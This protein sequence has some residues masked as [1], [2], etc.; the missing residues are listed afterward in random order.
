MVLFEER[1]GP[2]T[3]VG[4]KRREDF[5]RRSQYLIHRTLT[6]CSGDI[7]SEWCE[8]KKFLW[9]GGILLM[10]GDEDNG[11]GEKDDELW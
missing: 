4:N 2:I 10:L 3:D 6:I 9:Y 5:R 11:E 7:N 8:L 1:K